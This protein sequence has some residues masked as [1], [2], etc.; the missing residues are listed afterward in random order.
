MLYRILTE[1][2]HRDSIEA[3]VGTFFNGFTLIESIGWWKGSRE[4][5]LIIEIQDADLASIEAL[6]QKIKLLNQQE[7]VL[8][9]EI[10]CQ[11]KFV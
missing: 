5:G 7:S 6:A 10:Q 1:N 3:L 4:F 2:K 9:Q 8:V 11:A